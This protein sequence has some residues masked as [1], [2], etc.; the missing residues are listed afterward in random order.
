VTRVAIAGAGILGRR[1]ARVFHEIEESTLVGVADPAPDKARAAAEPCGAPAFPDL[2]ALLE[3]V[4]CDA[5]AIA[6]PD[7]LHTEPVLTALAAGKHVL[8]EKPL[9]TT[10]TDA[11]AMAAAAAERG[12]ILQVNYSQRHVPEYEWIQEQIDRGVIG[13]PAMLQSSKQDTVFVPTRMIPWAAATSPVFFMSSHDID[14]VARFAGGRAQR[15]LAHEHRGV[16]DGLGVPVH[17]GVDALVTFDNGALASFHSS[18]ILPDSYPSITVDRMILIGETGM[19]H[20]ESAGRE[21][22][23]YAAAGGRTLRFSGPQTATEVDGRIHGAFRTSLLRFLKAVR[24][25]VE[26]EASAARTLHVVEIQEAI[27]SAAASGR[28][29]LVGEKFMAS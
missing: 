21:V 14:L 22:Q 20:F 1:H 8:V 16:L 18:W 24:T 6:T 11:R 13:R 7:H 5:V 9:A 25:G 15:I 27:L 28:A 4:D 29:V 26:P 3:T 19:I 2:E 23:L 12:L 10:V 17:D